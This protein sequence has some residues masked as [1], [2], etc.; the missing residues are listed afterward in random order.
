MVSDVYLVSVFFNNY[1]DL[2]KD[3]YTEAGLEV[4]SDR[5]RG[6]GTIGESTK[7]FRSGLKENEYTG[8]PQVMATSLLIGDFD[9]HWGNIG[10][11]R[12]KG[13]KP[14]ISTH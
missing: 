8:F 10:V 3:I 4:P 14:K 9:V 11:V 12:D 6:I 5:P 13:K 1:K 7:I 2:Y